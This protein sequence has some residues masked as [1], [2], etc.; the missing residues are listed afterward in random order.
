MFQAAIIIVLAIGSIGCIPIESS[1]SNVGL[2]RPSPINPEVVSDPKPKETLVSASEKP[3]SGESWLQKIPAKGDKLSTELD[4]AEPS[5]SQEPKAKRQIDQP[6]APISKPAFKRD[7]QITT[8]TSS[9]KRLSTTTAEPVSLKTPI[10]HTSGA[11]TKRSADDGSSTSTNSTRPTSTRAPLISSDNS[12]NDNSGPHFVRPV[13][14]EQILKN[15]HEGS[16]AHQPSPIVLHHDEN[17]TEATNVASDTTGSSSDKKVYHKA[18][19]KKSESEEHEQEHDDE[20]SS[21][22]KKVQ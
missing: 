19:S 12:D 4:Q 8:T 3:K 1:S 16:R 20:D 9:P 6:E 5:I 17:K 13:P 7:Q 2:D 10:V 11:K 18:A 21:E 22:E 14:V 15:I